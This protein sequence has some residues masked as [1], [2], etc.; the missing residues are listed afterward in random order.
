MT[1]TARIE[2]WEIC[3]HS[4]STCYDA[5]QTKQWSDTIPSRVDILF[6][7][8]YLLSTS[9]DSLLDIAVCACFSSVRLLQICY[10]EYPTEEV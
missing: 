4:S 6:E 9:L 2:I 1:E 8:L 5:K 10:L 3:S 7:T